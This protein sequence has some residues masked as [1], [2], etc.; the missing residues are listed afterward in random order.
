MKR[1]FNQP[2]VKNVSQTFILGC[3]SFINYLKS[4][5]DAPE[6]EVDK[7]EIIS[8]IESVLWSPN[9]TDWYIQDLQVYSNNT[10]E[11]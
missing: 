7:K 1:G 3:S 4:R 9:L 10:D 11:E 2:P 8:I 5:Y 6:L